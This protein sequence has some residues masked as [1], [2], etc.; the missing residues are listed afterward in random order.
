MS[1]VKIEIKKSTLNIIYDNFYTL[2]WIVLS[3][4]V[5]DWVKNIL[6]NISTF[7]K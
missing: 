7:E 2:D 5:L 4:F 3:E 6:I 1:V